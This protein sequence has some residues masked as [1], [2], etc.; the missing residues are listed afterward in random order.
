MADKKKKIFA[1][2]GM[3]LAGIVVAGAVAALLRGKQVSEPVTVTVPVGIEY[4]LSVDDKVVELGAEGQTMHYVGGNTV[5]TVRVTGGV[6]G[7]LRAGKNGALIF[8]NV[9]F[10]DETTDN[11]GVAYERY[12]RFGGNLTF[13]HCTF[14]S[15]IYV[16]GDAQATFEHCTFT[17]AASN[18]YS[19][20]MA[21]GSARFESCLFV[22]ERGM[23]IHEFAGTKEDVKRVTISRCEFYQLWYKPGLA[24][25]TFTTPKNTVIE[26]KDSRFWENGSWDKSGCLA[27]VDSFYETDT[28]LSAITFKESGNIVYY[29]DDLYWTPNY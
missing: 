4:G 12:L 20:W 21:D 24:I 5:S 3:T 1:I 8:E 14:K 7:E 16:T 25:G 26:V 27:G 2:V 10:V 13:K 18:A 29:N 17:S 11:S 15:S 28:V 9:T 19:V 23:K 6:N 22:G